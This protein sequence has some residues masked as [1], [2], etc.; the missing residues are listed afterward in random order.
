MTV[1]SRI[2]IHEDFF[3]SAAILLLLLPIRWLLAGIAA[4]MVHELGHYLAVRLCGGHLVSGQVSA[5]GA[6][7]TAAPM[8]PEL[9]LLSLLAGPAA[10]LLLLSLHRLFPRI[11]ICGLVQG[12]F[13]L[14]PCY[15]L[16]GGKALRCC[17]SIVFSAIERKTPCKER[18]QRV[19]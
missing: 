14:L 2:R 3:F 15:P 13:N 16:D 6:K 18:K 7:L 11:A 4:A 12:C 10:S 5:R 1:P 8:K 9:E 19:Q 17:K